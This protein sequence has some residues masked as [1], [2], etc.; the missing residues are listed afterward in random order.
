MSQNRT[1]NFLL[2]Y[3]YTLFYILFL[4]ITGFLLT[5]NIA[6]VDNPV[7]ISLYAVSNVALVF[8]FFIFI[9]KFPKF[10][11]IPLLILM[12]LWLSFDM[13]YYL[14]YNTALQ[15]ANVAAIF[16]TN[17][18]EA[19]GLLESIYI[20]V[21]LILVFFGVITYFSVKEL[22]SVSVKWAFIVL[23]FIGVE[24]FLSRTP[25]F[26][27]DSGLNQFSL[28][29]GKFPLLFR[30]ITLVKDNFKEIDKIN[31]YVKEHRTVPKG[32]VLDANKKTPEKIFLI[33][34]ES[35]LSTHYS[36]YNYQKDTTPQLKE[37]SH[38]QSLIYFQNVIS[39]APITLLSLRNTL[40]FASPNDQNA[41]FKY[42]NIVEL[43]KDAG[44]ETV[45]LSVSGTVIGRHNTET[46][47]IARTSDL[48]KLFNYKEMGD[49]TLIPMMEKA[50]VP[51]KKQLIIL[52]V[53]GNHMSYNNFDASDAESIPGNDVIAK[54]DRT[55]H[56]TDRFIKKVYDIMKQQKE[57]SIMCY[58][59]DHGEVIGKGHGFLSEGSIQFKVPLIMSSNNATEM[60]T[61]KTVA[62]EYRSPSGYLNDLNLIYILSDFMGYSISQEQKEWGKSEGE[63]IYHVDHKPYRFLD[64]K[65]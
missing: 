4:L 54:Y 10:I 34:G 23:I 32:I 37:L 58:F 57:L 19:I 63:F 41:L 5:E 64:I 24:L 60:N 47:M 38:N 36:L 21:L 27:K 61:M 1:V 30:D 44:Y 46:S 55:I 20:K 40:S 31:E 7:T 62:E 49:W 15:P 18:K 26:N 50:I 48:S 17:N 53:R 25:L 11:K 43:A 16:T 42:K 59:S 2:K 28:A 12:V 8:I 56:N 65:K 6:Y 29:I 33:I 52:H 39:P 14:I 3:K 22:K 35:S 9:P 13:G 45:W 51:D